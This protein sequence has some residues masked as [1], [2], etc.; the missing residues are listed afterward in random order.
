MFFE[1]VSLNLQFQMYAHFHGQDADCQ[2]FSNGY[3]PSHYLIHTAIEVWIKWIKIEWM[4]R[5]K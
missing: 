1:S 5:M 4:V 2:R 3:D